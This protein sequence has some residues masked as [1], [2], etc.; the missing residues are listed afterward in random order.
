MVA[1]CLRNPSGTN[2]L[3]VVRSKHPLPAPFTLILW[4]NPCRL[5]AVTKHLTPGTRHPEYIPEFA[6]NLD[7]FLVF[8]WRIPDFVPEFVPEFRSGLTCIEFL[9]RKANPKSES[10]F[11]GGSRRGNSGM[12]FGSEIWKT[13]ERKKKRKEK[14]REA[15]LVIFFPFRRGSLILRGCYFL[16]SQKFQEEKFCMVPA[17]EYK[18]PDERKSPPDSRYCPSPAP[19]WFVSSCVGFRQKSWARCIGPLSFPPC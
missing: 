8:F 4:G 12:G 9:R 13:A 1:L 7:W 6:R 18:P 5:V 2:L 16:H 10:R 14:K 17:K 11:L 19:S 15:S 3:V